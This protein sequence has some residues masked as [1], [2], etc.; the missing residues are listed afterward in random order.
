MSRSVRVIRRK[1]RDQWAGVDLPLCASS[2][3]FDADVLIN[4]TSGNGSLAAPR[5]WVPQ[6]TAAVID[7][8]SGPPSSHSV[9]QQHRLLA[10][11]L[12]RAARGSAGEDVQHHDQRCHGQSARVGVD[13]TIFVA[14]Q[15]PA[16]RQT[17]AALAADLA[18][19][20]YSISAT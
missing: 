6:L 5:R 2:G 4:A 12:Q 9:R 16:A 11:Q 17:A 7:T 15:R 1:A 14:P 3:S 13:S 8:E 18:G 19:P 20:T 10:E